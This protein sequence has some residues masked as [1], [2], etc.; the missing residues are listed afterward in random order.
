[1][2]CTTLVHV[3]YADDSEFYSTFRYLPFATALVGF[4]R[5]VVIALFKSGSRSQLVYLSI[6]YYGPICIRRKHNF[7][8]TI[9]PI[10]SKFTILNTY[11]LI[12]HDSNSHIA[13]I[14]IFS[15]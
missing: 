4:A 3:I 10:V 1:M 14:Y 13:T 5:G 7:A 8:F 9:I 6:L 12:I 11:G 15:R 2:V